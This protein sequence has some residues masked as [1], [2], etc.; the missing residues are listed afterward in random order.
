M[1]ANVFLVYFSFGFETFQPKYINNGTMF[2]KYLQS[3]IEE[4]FD[5]M[6]TLIVFK[7]TLFVNICKAK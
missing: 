2:M 4:W 6:P 5:T 1:T 7:D 3:L